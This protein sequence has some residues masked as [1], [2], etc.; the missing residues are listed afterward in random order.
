MNTDT[1]EPELL[2]LAI[3]A[4]ADHAEL[5]I[6]IIALEQEQAIGGKIRRIDAVLKIEGAVYQAEIKRWAQHAP[7]GALIQQVEQFDNGILI[8]DY[9]NPNIAD[10]LRA[11]QVQ[12][13]D[14]AGNAFIKKPGL[15]IQIKGNRPASKAV[16]GPR[17]VARA[18]TTAG[19]KVTLALLQRR[20]RAEIP[21]REIA[22]LTGVTL[23]T[24]G[25]AMED[26]KDQGYLVNRRKER[27]LI[28]RPELFQIWV[29]RYPTALRQK[30][31]LGTFQAPDT[32]WW[33]HT[34]LEKL[35]GYWGGEIAAMHYT[36]YLKPQVATVY[37]PKE[38][39]TKLIVT[40]HLNKTVA[41]DEPGTVEVYEKF[42][43]VDQNEKCYVDPLLTYADLIAT[44]DTR[45]IET[46]RRL[47]DERIARH[48]GE[49]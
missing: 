49:T 32:D 11:A 7:I 45:N 24:V 26:L 27:V 25:K 16:A 3:I 28:R 19:L 36:K 21:Y 40:A 39:L 34:K 31:K 22:K 30:I 5:K 35:D 13:L 48:F 23:G 14:T 44:D 4:A 8:A 12:F 6:E 41:K 17:K 37:L 47:Y 20:E 15:H 46:A 10:R 38:K 2:D 1:T 42:W 29:A 43:M 18:F 33:K 9:V